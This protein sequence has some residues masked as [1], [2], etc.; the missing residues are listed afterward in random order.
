[1]RVCDRIVE[2][3]RGELVSSAGGYAEYLEARATRLE[4]E[5]RAESS[6]LNLL[7]RETAWMRRGPP[8]RTTKAKAR[9]RR[10]GDIAAAAPVALAAELEL[11]IPPGPRLGT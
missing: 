5:Q 8:A 2:L 9:I 6:R 7:R 11:E 1:D 10:Y 4:S 3:D